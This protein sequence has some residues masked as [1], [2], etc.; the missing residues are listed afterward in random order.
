MDVVKHYNIKKQFSPIFKAKVALE[1]IKERETIGQLSGK[2]Q[3]DPRQIGIWR[4][5]VLEGTESLFS[6]KEKKRDKERNEIM[7]ELQRLIGKQQIE[8]DFL[9]K[10]VGLFE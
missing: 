9:K 3:V 7:E 10:K 1:A 6:N 8:I 4:K 2:F 5:I